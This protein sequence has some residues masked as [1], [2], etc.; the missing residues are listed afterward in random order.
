VNRSEAEEF[1]TS[2]AMIH[3]GGWRLVAQGERLGVPTALGLTTRDWVEQRLGGY[4]RLSLPEQREA[5]RELTAEGRTQAEVGEIIGVHR[6]TVSR[7][8]RADAHEE[9]DEITVKAEGEHDERADAHR[10]ADLPPDL[11]SRV[12]QGMSLDEA[13]DVAA[14]R[15]KRVDAYV[16]RVRRALDVLERMA[17]YPVPIDV[18]QALTPS[19]R[20]LLKVVLAAI[21]ERRTNEHSRAA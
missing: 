13:E 1:T 11:A 7:H 21:P 5:V 6:S 10:L 2:L 16:G 8:Q 18:R 15:Q 12:E 20:Q 19:E 3:A 17:G 14:K 9:P 4:V